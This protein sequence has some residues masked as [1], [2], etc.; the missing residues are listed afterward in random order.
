MSDRTMLVFGRSTYSVPR[1][2]KRA[3]QVLLAVGITAVAI[4]LVLSLNNVLTTQSG[5]RQGFNAWYAFIRRSDILGT[6]VLTA[7]V[8][9]MSVY[10]TPE[11]GGNGG[12]K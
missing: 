5:W 2:T 3:F 9:V 4:L 1:L 10:W 6:M 12:K 8:S 7:V 11:N